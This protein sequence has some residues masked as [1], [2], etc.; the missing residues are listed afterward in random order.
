MMSIAFIWVAGCSNDTAWCL[1]SSNPT[2][3]IELIINWTNILADKRMD[4]QSL[5]YKYAQKYDTH[6]SLPFPVASLLSGH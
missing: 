4:R 5:A 1:N 3:K 6:S 2:Q